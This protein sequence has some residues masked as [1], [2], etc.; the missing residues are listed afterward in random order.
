MAWA[1]YF[2]IGIVLQP[3]IGG[4]ARGAATAA[5][6]AALAAGLLYMVRTWAPTFVV[7]SLTAKKFYK[8]ETGKS[9]LVGL[10]WTV[11][12]TIVGSI[13]ALI[14]AVSWE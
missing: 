11:A 10:V 3:L 8:L 12:A 2:V 4:A 7:N 5:T 6:G 1:I 14:M 13:Y 9:F